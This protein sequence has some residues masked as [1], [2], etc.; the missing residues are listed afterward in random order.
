[1]VKTPTSADENPQS[2]ELIERLKL[3]KLQ[4]PLK[5]FKPLSL[6]AQLSHPLKSQNVFLQKYIRHFL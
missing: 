4:K 3:F 6:P 2:F 1:M 5:R